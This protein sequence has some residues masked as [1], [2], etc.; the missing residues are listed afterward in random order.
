MLWAVHVARSGGK[1]HISFEG[2][3]PR[4][5]EHF[6]DRRR[7]ENDIRMDVQEVG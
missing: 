1:G 6:K 5:G 2:R 4:E 3:Q 7:W